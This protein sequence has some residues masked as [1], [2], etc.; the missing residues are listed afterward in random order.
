MGFVFSGYSRACFICFQTVEYV[1][2][3]LVSLSCTPKLNSTMK[4]KKNMTISAYAI[5]GLKFRIKNTSP[6]L[7]I[8]QVCNH[9]DVRVIDVVSELKGNREISY[10]RDWCVWFIIKYFKRYTL[11]KVGTFFSCRHYSTIIC[12]RN[13]V[14]EGLYKKDTD[15]HGKYLRDY[16]L[17]REKLNPYFNVHNNKLVA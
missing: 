10:A 9:L 14:R 13:R 7:I 8:D 6:D 15:L 4:N 16:K 3:S 17:L 5:P 11:E 1:A 2:S 12:S